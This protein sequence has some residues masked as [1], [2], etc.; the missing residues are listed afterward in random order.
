VIEEILPADVA[1]AEAQDDPPGARLFSE[2][3]PSLARA[4]HRRRREFTTGRLCARRALAELG[5]PPVPLP[6][7][8]NGEPQWPPGLVGSIT[9]CA[10]YRAA[11]AARTG[12][13]RAVGID[14]ETHGALPRAVANAISL[15]E[16]HAWVREL[17]RTD[18]GVWWDRLLFSAKESVYKAWFP[19][20]NR[21]LG[22]RQAAITVDPA[23]TFSARLLVDGLR[24]DGRELGGFTG[25]WLVRDGLVLTAVALGAQIDQLR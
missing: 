25:R 21:W 15:P 6:P 10:G 18:P 14:A 7:G 16:E 9:H 24:I 22:F 4:V 8:P 12:A 23:G 5:S 13:V 3:E 17:S 20:T 1:T 11:A 2:E 19:L